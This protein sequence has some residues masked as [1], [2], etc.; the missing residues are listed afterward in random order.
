MRPD[1]IA[2]PAR[3]TWAAVLILAGA[4]V[5]IET[6]TKESL[7]LERRPRLTTKR[8]DDRGASLVR[9]EASTSARLVLPILP[10]WSEPPLPVPGIWRAR[11][12]GVDETSV[13]LAVEDS[14]HRIFWPEPLPISIGLYELVAVQADEASA[15]LFFPGGALAFSR[16]EG[17][18]VPEAGMR[19]G[20]IEVR[21]EP[22]CA[23]TE[24]TALALVVDDVR[25]GP[26]KTAE[27]G[28]WRITNQEALVDACLDPDKDDTRAIWI[29]R[30]V[31]SRLECALAFPPTFVCQEEV[32]TAQLRNMDREVGP[33]P[34]E[35]TYEVVAVLPEEIV[36][37]PEGENTITSFFWYE[38]LPFP[39]SVAEQVVVENRN[40]WH[41]LGFS[42]GEMAIAHP[43]LPSQSPDA[44]FLLFRKRC[45]DRDNRAI[46]GVGLYSDGEEEVIWPGESAIK[47][48]WTYRVHYGWERIALSCY[49][50]GEF[51]FTDDTLI[52]GVVLAYRT[53]E[54]AR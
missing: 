17:P 37:R 22:H 27:V 10:P 3:W 45:L 44:R 26:G 24:G 36:L 32:V 4:C 16:S 35:G 20:S 49:A 9:A 38:S 33:A 29:A 15:T 28:G 50:G 42:L 14:I 30:S 39:V 46:W 19:I 47:E 5:Q 21:W 51:A 18:V 41:V 34:E 1:S 8:C 54:E 12:V 53:F 11:V 7:C 43:S 13:L 48:G 25:I 31:E 52:D 2:S 23:S 40:G 6:E